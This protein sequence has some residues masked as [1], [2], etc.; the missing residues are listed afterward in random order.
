MFWQKSGDFLCVR[1]NRTTKAGK[2]IFANLELFR[3]RERDVPVETLRLDE[4]VM[5]VAWE[6]VGRRL[7]VVHSATATSTTPDVSLYVMAPAK[8]ELIK[9]LESKK[10]NALFWAPRGKFLI[11]AGTQPL[12][13]RI[14]FWN[15]NDMRMMA[16][17][18]HFQMNYI[19]WDP[20]GRYVA[21]AACR[22]QV[23]HGFKIFSFDGRLLHE[24]NR[25]AF[26]LLR[27]RP[28]P[29]SILTPDQLKEIHRSLPVKSQEY[30]KIDYLRA[31][32][33]DG[34]TRSRRR[35]LYAQFT[36]MHGE[37]AAHRERI[38]AERLA[39]FGPGKSRV[40]T[41]ER[42]VEVLLEEVIIH[43]D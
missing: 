43:E 30:D 38:A 33:L 3:L 42:E 39:R 17:D 20:T 24:E 25:D 36:Q 27:W 6:P 19:E 37:W 8:V 10:T 31:Q 4:R 16:T 34:E 29:L 15:V 26:H 12:T 13:G 18:E 1:V 21:T 32:E 7:A 22:N 2:T 23:E 9:T 28:R 14:E 41:E 11:I 35:A 40:V 5:H